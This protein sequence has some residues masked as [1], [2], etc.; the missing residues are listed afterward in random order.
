M[1]CFG[2]FIDDFQQIVFVV[3]LRR[4]AAPRQLDPDARRNMLDRFRK[5]EALGE[6][7]KLED[8]AAGAAAEAVEESFV[9]IDMKRRRLLAMKRTESFV[10]LPGELERRD[11]ADEV[12]D[13]RRTAHLRDHAVIEIYKGHQ[14]PSR[15]PSPEYRMLDPG[16][17]TR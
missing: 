13:V 1:K 9:A 10:A 2:R 6:R 3:F 17:G 7:E 15:V 12:D 16:P 14:Q 5:R 4:L 8:V 11:L